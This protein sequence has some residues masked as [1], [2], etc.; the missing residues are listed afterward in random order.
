MAKQTFNF[1]FMSA[2]EQVAKFF[3]WQEASYHEAILCLQ[4]GDG[5]GALSKLEEVFR[6][7]G[8]LEATP[9]YLI[10]EAALQVLEAECPTP[11]YRPNVVLEI[12]DR[13]VPSLSVLARQY[14]YERT[15][16]ALRDL[17]STSD[18]QYEAVPYAITARDWRDGFAGKAGAAV[19][20][21]A[22]E[23]GGVEGGQLDRL[24]RT[25][26][27][28]ME[29][30]QGEGESR[31]L[32]TL[33]AVDVLEALSEASQIHGQFSSGEIPSI[34]HLLFGPHEEVK[35]EVQRPGVEESR[36]HNPRG[37]SRSAARPSTNLRPS[38]GADRSKEG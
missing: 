23:I 13:T 15:S 11:E 25:A 16:R 30:E 10:F 26:Q 38:V 31:E 12:H 27:L 2:E 20:E 6:Q 5:S 24:L 28:K 19:P 33:K 3:S 1:E 32:G 34:T 29:C 18:L 37:A 14:C 9:H 8:R 17:S 36:Q 7:C 35:R 22:E 4:S 21:I